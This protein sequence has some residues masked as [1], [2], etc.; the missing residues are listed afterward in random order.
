MSITDLQAR[1]IREARSRGDGYKAIAVAVG[2]SRDTVRN[3]CKANGLDGHAD[4]VASVD[5]ETA[6]ACLHCGKP[7]AQPRT[8]RKRKFCSDV[9]R[10]A[11]WSAHPSALQSGASQTCACCGKTFAAFESQHRRYCR[12]A[13]YVHYRFQKSELS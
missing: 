9:C 8:G 10:R 12:H 5:R 4:V 2:L 1:Q 6:F 11:W 7:V 3:F 13:C